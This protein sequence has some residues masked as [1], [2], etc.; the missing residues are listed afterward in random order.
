MSLALLLNKNTLL[1]SGMLAVLIG[2]FYGGAN[3]GSASNQLK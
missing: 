1:A 3:W 2:V